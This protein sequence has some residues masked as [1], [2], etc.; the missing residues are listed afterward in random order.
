MADEEAMTTDEVIYKVVEAEQLET[1]TMCG[2]KL[3]RVLGR[4]EFEVTNDS[5]V[6]PHAGEKQ[7]YGGQ[8]AD[9]IME[10]RSIPMQ[11]LSFLL[12]MSGQSVLATMDRQ[13]KKAIE[14]EVEAKKAVPDLEKQVATLETDKTTLQ[15]GWAAEQK[16][17]NAALEAKQTAEEKAR[18][19]ESYFQ[20]IRK[21]IGDRE[22]DRILKE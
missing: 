13:M 12:S 8:N 19:M 5:V 9:T 11:S 6:H 1:E 16:K 20:A 7:D 10:S 21:D 4:T 14:G 18:K 2:W 22:M 3:E 17:C 15:T